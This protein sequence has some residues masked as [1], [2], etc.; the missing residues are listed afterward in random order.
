M[1]E[2][3]TG[4]DNP[5]WLLVLRN[6]WCFGQENCPSILNYGPAASRGTISNKNPPNNGFWIF[7]GKT[8]WTQMIPSEGGRSSLSKTDKIWRKIFDYFF[9]LVH[10]PTHIDD[11]LWCWQV[12]WWFWK[13]AISYSK[14]SR[15]LIFC[16]WQSLEREVSL[17]FHKKMNNCC[18]KKETSPQAKRPDPL[19]LFTFLLF[20]LVCVT[21]FTSLTI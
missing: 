10:A 21:I 6:R 19:L 14:F 2:I 11:M 13:L 18:A 17:R 3:C 15:V 20:S 16:G 9:L 12:W 1:D 4:N 7:L 8:I 5:S